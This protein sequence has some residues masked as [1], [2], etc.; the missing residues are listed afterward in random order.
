MN[1]SG[2]FEIIKDDNIIASSYPNP[3]DE[4]DQYQKIDDSHLFNISDFQILAQSFKPTMKYLSRV[5]LKIHQGFYSSNT[6]LIV[7]VKE[8][9][10]GK[11]LTHIKIKYQ[12]INTSNNNSSYWFEFDFPDISL[13]INDEYFII[14]RIAYNDLYFGYAW[15][16][17]MNS[18]IIDHYPNGSMW[19]NNLNEDFGWMETDQDACF[20]TYGYDDNTSIPDLECEGSLLWEEVKPG[21]I[22]S[23]NFDIKN[24]GDLNSKLDWEIYEY[25]NWGEWSFN[26]VE[27]YGINGDETINVKVTVVTPNDEDSYFSGLIKI[28][29]KNNDNDRD[30]ITVTITTSKIRNLNINFIRELIKI[31]FF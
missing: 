7:S 1:I 3:E 21:E 28:K 12:D 26:P 6:D 11:D 19:I 24:I 15:A 18:D 20:I 5:E 23:G 9:V 27:G 29:N 10:D 4:E 14:A 25:P 8:E 31:F 13:T 22:M 2:M 16:T 17:C 30:V